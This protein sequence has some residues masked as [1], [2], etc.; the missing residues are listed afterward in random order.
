MNRR[1]FLKL[2]AAAAV[3]VVGGLVLSRLPQVPLPHDYVGFE[4]RDASHGFEQGF[5]RRTI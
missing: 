4:R 3:T 1:D 2:T 5:E